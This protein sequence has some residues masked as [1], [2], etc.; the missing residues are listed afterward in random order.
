MQTQT[1]NSGG[2]DLIEMG[3]DQWAMNVRGGSLFVGSFRKV[4]MHSVAVLGFNLKEIEFAV[5]EM[6]DKG[7]NSAH[8]GMYKGFIFTF[9]KDFTNAI[10]TKKIS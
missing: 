4:V 1:N 6:L 7:H 2:Y 8:F 5:K 10:P 9:E 3:N